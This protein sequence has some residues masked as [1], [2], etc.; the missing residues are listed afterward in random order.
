MQVGA[1]ADHHNLIPCAPARVGEA[2]IAATPSC[3]SIK[4]AILSS[5]PARPGAGARSGGPGCPKGTAVGG[6]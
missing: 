4:T 5:R 2:P 1:G 6:A 3:G